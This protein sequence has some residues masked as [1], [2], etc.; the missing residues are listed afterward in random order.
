MRSEVL[1]LSR[2]VK[3]LASTEDISYSLKDAWG[4]RVLVADFYEKDWSYQ[5]G[6]LYM[7]Y[8]EIKNCSQRYTFKPALSWEIARGG[9]SSVT[10]SAIHSG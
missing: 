5:A 3:I 10:N 6:N 9:A 2:N 7:D 4:C 1:M 8:V